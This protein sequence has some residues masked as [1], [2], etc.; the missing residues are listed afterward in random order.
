MNLKQLSKQVGNTFRFRPLPIR[1]DA[2]G[3]RLPE[4]DDQWCLE[5]IPEN[6]TR[7]RLVNIH[8]AHIVELGSDN[9]RE[10][11]TPNF[12]LLRCNL[13]ISAQDI[14]IEPIIQQ[15][16]A[17]RSVRSGSATVQLRGAPLKLLGYCVQRES[18]C[19]FD[20]AEADDAMSALGLTAAQYKSAA[21]ELADLGLVTTHGDANHSSGIAR[22]ILRPQA[23][24]ATASL[25]LPAVD[26]RKEL[27]RLFDSLRQATE[28]HDRIR[29]PELLQRNLMPLARLDLVLRG[30]E[31]LG[32]LVGHG[33]G[34][35]DWG[36]SIDVEITP[37]GRRM[38][39][40]D[41][42]FPYWMND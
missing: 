11:R 32:Y 34:H 21:D 15:P 14:R 2:D 40:G 4:S 30:L 9:V 1:V 27:N 13:F 5:G 17:P 23:F 18:A 10:F 29:V 24:F 22:T 42:P 25:F 28:D 41:D 39:R 33:P 6:P 8:T 36:S 20:Y 26:L 37:M 12:L 31:D 35:Q 7:L 38:L 3:S 16:Q 19:L